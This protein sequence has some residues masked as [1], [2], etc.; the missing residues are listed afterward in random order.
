MRGMIFQTGL[1]RICIDFLKPE[2]G[3]GKV[4]KSQ[5]NIMIKADCGG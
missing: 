4:K 3:F 1:P 5:Q 2:N